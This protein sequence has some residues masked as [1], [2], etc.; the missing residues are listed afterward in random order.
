MMNRNLS[1]VVTFGC[2]GTALLLTLSGCAHLSRTG[3][4]A[5]TTGDCRKFIVKDKNFESNLYYCGVGESDLVGDTYIEKQKAQTR[6]NGRIVESI[7][8]VVDTLNKD[9][10]KETKLNNSADTE[11]RFETATKGWAQS[12]IIGVTY[13]LSYRGADTYYV[14]CQSRGEVASL[15]TLRPEEREF[16]ERDA[17]K[18]FDELANKPK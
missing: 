5:W 4:P 14:L 3:G 15:Q 17:Q 9:F 11:Q 10:A 2:F 7:K 16:V 13:P 12:T 1:R 8:T 6:C 18:A